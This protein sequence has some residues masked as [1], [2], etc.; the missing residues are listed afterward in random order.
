LLL[1]AYTIALAPPGVRKVFWYTFTDTAAADDNNSVE[2][3]F[4]L[5]TKA[6]AYKQSLRAMQFVHTQLSGSR[7]VQQQWLEKTRVDDFST[8][9][10][11]QFSGTV[12]TEGSVNA[13]MNEMLHVTYEFS[14]DTAQENCY[15]PVMRQQELAAQT[16]A[17]L[18]RAKGD[19][20]N[21]TLRLRLVDATGETFQYTVGL[22]PPRWLPYTVQT[23]YFSASWGG[24]EDGELDQPLI[25][26]S[27]VLDNADGENTAGEIYI[28]DLY[29][30]TAGD[31]FLYEFRE[32]RK[33][34]FAYWSSSTVQQQTV[35][36]SGIDSIDM[37]LFSGEKIQKN[38]RNG[39]FT[40]WAR[41]TM[42][43]FAES[44]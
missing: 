8:D 19:A 33:A 39:A 31:I 5:V 9:S 29:S 18:F 12:C 27:F 26:D 34:L 35:P 20:T 37:A 11:W 42:K 6:L 30:T 24:N 14:A 22:L 43:F 7:F 40:L 36:L 4:G 16:N 32:A 3:Q 25:F 10:G 41:P 21:T 15:A 44:L 28:D 13:G 17:I 23:R 38:K 1:R 2:G